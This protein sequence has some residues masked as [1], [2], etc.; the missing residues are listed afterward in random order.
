VFSNLSSFCPSRFSRALKTD[1]RR[2]THI[3][4]WFASANSRSFLRGRNAVFRSRCFCAERKAQPPR[5]V[6]RLIALYPASWFYVIQTCSPR[7]WRTHLV[8]TVCISRFARAP[9]CTYTRASRAESLWEERARMCERVACVYVHTLFRRAQT[10][11]PTWTPDYRPAR[12][13][14]GETSAFSPF[15]APFRTCASARTCVYVSAM[16]STLSLSLFSCEWRTM[17][18]KMRRGEK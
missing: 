1:E 2:G 4:R 14:C 5:F 9:V 6:G 11:A 12:S 7:V 10:L 15:L 3:V 16:L 8:A 17:R 18:Y 13:L